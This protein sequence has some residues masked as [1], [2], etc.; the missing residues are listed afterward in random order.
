MNAELLIAQFDRIAE[1]P[2]AVPRLRRFILDLAVRGRLVNQDPKEGSAQLL[3]AEITEKKRSLVEQRINTRRGDV[4][5]EVPF[6]IPRTW[7][8]TQLG[9]IG[10]VNPQ[11]KGIPDDASVSFVPMHRIPNQYG[12]SVSYEVRP[13]REIKS[14]FTHFADGDVGLAKITPSF[15]NGKSTVFRNLYGGMGAG[16]TELHVI[17]PISV[18][19]E[20]ILLFLKS[21]FFMDTAIP[22]MTGTAGQKRVPRSYFAHAPFPLPPLAEQHRIVAKVNALMTVCDELEV[23]QREREVQR[24]R[25]VT[26]ISHKLVHEGPA[27]QPLA[28]TVQFYL[29]NF[30]DLTVRREHVQQWRR[31]ILDLAVRG[32]LVPQRFDEGTA[33]YILERIRGLMTSSASIRRLLEIPDDYPFELPQSWRWVRLGEIAHFTI[34]KT[35]SRYD[36]SFWNTGDYHWVSIADMTDGELVTNTKETVSQK[37]R[38]FVFKSSPSPSGTIL[39]SFKLTVGRVSRLAVPAFHNE[40][41]ISIYPLL[42]ELDPFLFRFLGLFSQWGIT[43]NAI[44]GSTL[45]RH[46]LT[47]LLIALPPLAEQHR[48]VAKV[49]ALMTVCDELEQQLSMQEQDAERFMETVLHGVL[50]PVVQRI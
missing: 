1:T 28:K 9:N 43:K 27:D 17:R 11:N 44:K 31:T 10:I 50:T 7:V 25:V 21:S 42:T 34:G 14:G 5:L 26:A 22:L 23:R 41:I 35:P 3:L 4:N 36:D 6:E 47:N 12:K 30:A 2:D 16:T 40:A 29:R 33:D 37:A 49:N 48:I 13:W 18:V 32:R 24:N 20:Y 39:M 46:S 19:P 15:E 45:N 8:W 38:D